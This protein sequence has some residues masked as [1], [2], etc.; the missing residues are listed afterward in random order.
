MSRAKKGLGTLRHGLVKD[1][2]KRPTFSE[3][4]KKVSYKT[5]EHDDRPLRPRLY[6]RY[7]HVINRPS[8]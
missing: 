1:H 4:I 7:I 3:L 2:K 8:N 5:F 6:T